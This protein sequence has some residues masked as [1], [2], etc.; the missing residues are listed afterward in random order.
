M[1]NVLF[2]LPGLLIA[3]CNDKPAPI[4][5]VTEQRYFIPG[6]YALCEQANFCTT[7]DTLIVSA[8][9]SLSNKFRIKR[10]SCFQRNLGEDC[11]KEQYVS[12]EWMGLYDYTSHLLSCANSNKQL[13]F[14][15]AK[16]SIMLFGMIYQRVK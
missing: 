2:I 6:T 16:S 7:W 13:E 9:R 14:M 8:D 1:R 5:N 4:S 10:K 15:P 12:S 11:F 3:A